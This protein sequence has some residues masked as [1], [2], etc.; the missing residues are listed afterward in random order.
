MR[1][2][3]PHLA[4]MTAIFPSIFLLIRAE[5]RKLR[6]LG[7]PPVWFGVP[8]KPSVRSLT[9]TALTIPPMTA[10]LP[11]VSPCNFRP[12]AAPGPMPARHGPLRPLIVTILQPPPMRCSPL[13]VGKLTSRAS[14]APVL[15]TLP[16]V[17]KIPGLLLPLKCRHT[18]RPCLSCSP[19]PPLTALSFPGPLQSPI[20]S[21]NP[22][23]ASLSPGPGLSSPTRRSPSIVGNR[24]LSR[25]PRPCNF[26]VSSSNDD[27]NAQAR[28]SLRT[29]LRSQDKIVCQIGDRLCIRNLF[30]NSGAHGCNIIGK[31]KA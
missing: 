11:P 2:A 20:L 30:E 25:L 18:R 12:M 3:P 27:L 22:P 7:K 31:P 21:S 4:S 6:R 1:P 16:A 13:P 8:R 10:F 9:S 26:S 5:P 14:V 19:D 24:S 23:A 15:F 28:L 17:R 29:E